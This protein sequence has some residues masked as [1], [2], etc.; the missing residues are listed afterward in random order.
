M[1]STIVSLSGR[2]I[3]A[4]VSIAACASPPTPGSDVRAPAAGT[5]QAPGP[6]QPGAGQPSGGPPGTGQ[7]GAT[8]PGAPVRLV[9]FITVDQLR[10]D[11][12]TERF[13]SQLTGGLGRLMRGGAFFVH[14]VHDHAT[15]E[16]APGHASTL[17]GRF[18]RST[19][20]V[21]NNMGVNTPDAPMIG[22]GGPGASPARF[23][24][25]TLVDWMIARDPRTK[26]LSVSRKDRSAILPI[27]RSRQPVYWYAS[28][29]RFTTSTY[30][31]DTLPTWVQ[32]FNAQRLP[33][34]TAG[35]SWDLLLPESAY[36]EPDSVPAEN[37]GRDF[38]FPHPHPQD[39]TNAARL[40]ANYP[41]MDDVTLDFALE[42]IT[43]LGLGLGPQTDVL[44]IGLST[45]DAV[46]HAYGPDSRE[47]RDQV[48]RVD[49]M[50]ATFFDSLYALR[51]SSRIVVAL[52]AD[53]G[54]GRIAALHF[55]STA[56]GTTS[57]DTM[58]ARYRRTLAARRVDTSTVHF[59]PG[60]F[61]L[62]RAEI[63]RARLSVDSIYRAFA[64]D[65]RRVTRVLRADVV[66]DLARADTINDTIARR[67]LHSLPPDLDVGVV[68][69]LEPYVYW[70]A[71]LTASH[72]TPHDYDARVPVIF[73]GPEFNSRRFDTPGRVVDMAPTLAA[74]LGVTP[75]ERLDGQVLTTAIKAR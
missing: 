44:A 38:V 69:T 34:R 47:I 55:G 19:G 71:G 74:I 1:R 60:M 29:G 39:S 30:Y 52:T 45:T 12:L 31:A 54:V 50:L 73:Y 49:R 18:P 48:L 8:Q 67:W 2:L 75:L 62:D 25:T 36:P 11:Y 22:G 24:G 16:T 21:R 72:G 15:T 4:A 68:I 43:A 23:R 58:V 37:R 6:G 70:G 3:L 40:L 56:A 33:H 13:T 63:T 51:D 35:E 64:R 32:R 26:V 20:I 27:G 57:L 10:T 17:S 9:V 66:A 61:S 46:G 5:V 7:P 28:D 65:A 53:H 41:A 14:G 42:G 59:E